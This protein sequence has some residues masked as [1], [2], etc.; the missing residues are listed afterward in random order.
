M[1]Y[2]DNRPSTITVTL[3]AADRKLIDKLR[4]DRPMTLAETI[5]EA[6]S[7]AAKL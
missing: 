1:Q 5:L 4:Q 3:T 2:E 7:I 6:I